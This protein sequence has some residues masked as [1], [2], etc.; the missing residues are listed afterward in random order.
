MEK[1]YLNFNQFCL[2]RIIKI[3]K[4]FLS[5]LK[6]SKIGCLIVLTIQ[7]IKIYNYDKPSLLKTLF[8]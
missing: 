1:N 6:K 8:E 5:K 7:I 2:L 3:L 4:T